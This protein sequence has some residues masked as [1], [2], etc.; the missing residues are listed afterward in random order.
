MNILV[1]CEESQRVTIECRKLGHNAFSCDLELC[2]GG[3]EEWH[4]QHDVIPYLNGRCKF[5][6]MDGRYHDIPKRWDMIIGHPPCTY[7]S[8]AGAMHLFPGG[9]LNEERYQLGMDARAFFM[10]IYN[11]DC[12]KIAVENP[13][14]STIFELPEYSQIIQPYEF[15]HPFSKKT[16]LWL[17]GLPLLQPTEIITDNIESTTIARWFNSGGVE[18]QKNRSKTFWGIAKAMARQWAGVSKYMLLDD[19]NNSLT[20]YSD[21]RNGWRC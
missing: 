2:S 14:P 21:I 10:R 12:E 6:T 9:E 4:I 18:R 13:I 5:M 19:C 17:K 1:A 20:S 16:C 8:N 7:L 15:G 11:A 3:H